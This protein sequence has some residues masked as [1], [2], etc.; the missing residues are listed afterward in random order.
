MI[1]EKLISNNYSLKMINKE[2]NKAKQIILVRTQKTADQRLVA[3]VIIP[4]K[5]KIRRINE[6]FGIR[7][8]FSTCL[9][10]RS[11]LTRVKPKNIIQ[12]IKH[13]IY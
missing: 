13:L 11:I 7:T 8:S 12:E 2:F 1:N 10:L 4:Y 3:A 9:T 6:G 5:E